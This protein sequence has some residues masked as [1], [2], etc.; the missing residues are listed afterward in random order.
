VRALA[1]IS[2]GL[3][4]ILAARLVMDQG[5]DVVGVSFESPF[6]NADGA[7]AATE[8]LGIDLVVIDIG[9]DLLEV[10]AAPK[11]GFGKHM[12]PCI[13]CHALMVRRAGERMEPLGASFLVTGEVIGQRPKSQMR[14]GLE[15]VERE[16]GLAGLILRP[17]SAKLLAPTVPER[18]GSVD[19][20]RLLGLHGRTRKPQL[21][22]ARHYGITRYLSPAGGCLLTDENV[23][24]ALKDLRAHG[25]VT[26]PMV[27]L[28]SVGRQ[29]RLSERAKLSVG[30]NHSENE[31]LFG[32]KPPGA[33]FVK[34]VDRKGPV[35]VLAGDVNNEDERLAASV[36]ARYADTPAGE[37]V[38]AQVW[39]GDASDG[40]REFDV[41]PLPPEKVRGYKV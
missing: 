13:D 23:A 29:F 5:I 1:L 19:R 3:D 33:L 27:R 21:E 28:L 24:R 16:S 22:L 11:Y 41:V 37:T 17:L 31:A 35:G 18:E 15:A 36:V 4:S 7:R 34:A 32:L 39:S 12:N 30:R 9:E 26:I 2:G 25:Q 40:A 14:F 8:E 38:R 20:D 6:F 10:I